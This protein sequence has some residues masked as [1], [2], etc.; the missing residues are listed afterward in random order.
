MWGTAGINKHWLEWPQSASVAIS[1]P[2]CTADVCSVNCLSI[3]GRESPL[4]SRQAT[5]EV[6]LGGYSTLKSDHM[7]F[8]ICHLTC[9]CEKE[10]FPLQFCEIFLFRIAR[11]TFFAI[12][13]SFCE[14]DTFPLGIFS[15]LNFNLRNL[16]GNGNAPSKALY[17]W[18]PICICNCSFKTVILMIQ[19][20]QC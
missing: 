11:K 17:E 2:H 13:G 16:K 20:N 10:K 4:Y 8:Y 1:E 18:Y 9:K 14:I 5:Y 15:I 3:N 19:S 6:F 12:Y 7:T